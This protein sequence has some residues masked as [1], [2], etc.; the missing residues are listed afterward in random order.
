MT[1]GPIRIPVTFVRGRDETRTLEFYTDDA[2]TAA[3]NITGRTYVA[4]FATT[5]G[6]SIVY[7]VTGTVTG[8]SGRVTFTSTDTQTALLTG[9][10]YWWD[11]VETS[12]TTTTQIVLGPVTVQTGVTA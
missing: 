8:A 11:V 4:S 12:G 6:A 10:T 9:T 1:E 3:L 7:A 5:P 2:G